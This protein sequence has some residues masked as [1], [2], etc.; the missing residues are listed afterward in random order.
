MKGCKRGGEERRGEK[1]KGEGGDERG[2]KRTEKGGKV[3]EEGKGKGR[4]EEAG[5][6][7]RREGLLQSF[8]LTLISNFV[9]LGELKMYIVFALFIL[10]FKKFSKISHPLIFL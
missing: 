6:A 7:E 10:T 1:K 5:G 4:R 9:L 3:R 2:E 8:Q